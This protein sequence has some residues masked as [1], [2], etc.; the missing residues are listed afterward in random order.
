LITDRNRHSVILR[1]QSE[2]FT[3]GAELATDPAEYDK[4]QQHFMVVTP[5]FT[6]WL[7]AEI[8][9]LEQQIT[10]PDAFVIPGGTP[11]A[12]ALDVAR[13]V[14][15]RAERRIVGLQQ[16]GKLKNPE[17]L[18]YVNRLS[19]LLFMLARA[20]EGLAVKPLTGRR[21]DRIPAARARTRPAPRR[22]LRG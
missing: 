4:L 1:I 5:D 3:V 17:V 2:L 7:E 8:V 6:R 14:T 19:D 18:R 21:A 12:A 15:R 16:V 22:R 9:E 11:A 10:L 13:T 20:E